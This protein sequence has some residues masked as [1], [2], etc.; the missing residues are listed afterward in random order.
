MLM[1]MLITASHLYI[2]TLPFFPSPSTRCSQVLGR[3]FG[4]F[5]GTLMPLAKEILSKTPPHPGAD[6]PS[7]DFNG[8]N[9][10]KK[11]QNTDLLRGKA[12]EAIALMG[13]AVGIG[14]F[15]DD[16]HLVSVKMI[17]CYLTDTDTDT[18]KYACRGGQA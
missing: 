2:L 8:S 16:A 10:L 1:L 5:Y 13:Q 3:G 17:Q 12:M 11:S 7:E 15:R 4:S 9:V 6:Y 18:A 14:V